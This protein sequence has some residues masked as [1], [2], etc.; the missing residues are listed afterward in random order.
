MNRIRIILSLFVLMWMCLSSC[1]DPL[2]PFSQIPISIKTDKRQYNLNEDDT[3][4]VTIT[5]NSSQRIFYSTCF[6]KTIEIIKDDNIIKRIGIPVCRCICS[7]ELKP[8]ES[9]PINIS[10]LSEKIFK[11][12]EDNF[13]VDESVMYQIRYSLYYDKA[14]GDEPIPK[15][16]SRSNTF[17]L[18]GIE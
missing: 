1:N 12:Q 2:A 3:I 8:S 16:L 10:S 9:I 18:S 15:E 13:L 5:N 11:Y 6:D 4:K 14:F 17:L 7:A